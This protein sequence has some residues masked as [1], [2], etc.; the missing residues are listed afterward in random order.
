MFGR[1]SSEANKAPYG[2]A[3][4]LLAS[5]SA[6]NLMNAYKEARYALLPP[7]KKQ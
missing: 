6:K 7:Q 3:T 4:P 1:N 5:R 2:A